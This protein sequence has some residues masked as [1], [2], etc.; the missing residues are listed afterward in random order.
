MTRPVFFDAH[1]LGSGATGNETWARGLI[2]ALERAQGEAWSYL[3]T[4]EGAAQL[5]VGV[6]RERVLHVPT[7][8]TRRL[9]VTAPR[10]V[11][12][13][14]P[15]AVVAQYSLPAV[16]VAGV[17][18]VHDLSFEAPEAREWL[19]RGSVARYRA[20]I[21]WSVRRARAVVVPSAWTRDDLLRHFDVAGDQVFVAPCGV[22]PDFAE[23]LRA[24]PREVPADPVVLVVGTVLPRKNLTVVARAVARLRAG[25]TPAVL[26][27]VGPVP[28]AGQQEL[29]RLRCILPAGLDEWGFVNQSRLV[30]AYRTSSVL[31]FPSK[32]EGFGIPLAEAMTAGLPAVVSSAT[33]LPEVA[34][35]AAIEVAP[36]DEEGWSAGLELAM[37]TEAVRLAA[38]G[39]ARVH[40]LDWAEAAAVVRRAV[41]HAVA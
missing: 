31:A 27:L 15:R 8:S 3:V 22:D 18:A 13:W 12:R 30:D 40:G 14:Q 17:V 11:R 39:R 41:D 26:R 28:P 33:C 2:G 1:Q 21:R 35:G 4:G 24:R 23:A 5:P 34:G 38:A 29:D 19:S 20:T 16:A 10:L 7:S 6:D 36:D 25:G 37:G 32:F 9:L